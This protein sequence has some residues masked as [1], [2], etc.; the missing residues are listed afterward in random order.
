M[1][2]LTILSLTFSV[3]NTLY[4]WFWQNR[5]HLKLQIKIRRVYS[6][7]GTETGDRILIW[8]IANAST[9]AVYIE[10]IGF[11]DI[12]YASMVPVPLEFIK[13]KHKQEKP[14]G[15]PY[16]LESREGISVVVAH[17]SQTE[18]M[19]KHV[20]MY[21]KTCCGYSTSAFIPVASLL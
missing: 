15:F 13:S 9:F 20:K 4:L 1:L 10:E 3:G 14:I 5:V 17:S 7:A 18:E 11:C 19:R 16:K 12:S 6:A 2:F 21:V 8:N